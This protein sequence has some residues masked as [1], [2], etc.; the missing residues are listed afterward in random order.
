MK[1]TDKSIKITDLLFYYT[2]NNIDKENV[3]IGQG[4][5]LSQIRSAVGTGNGWFYPGNITNDGYICHMETYSTTQSELMYLSK[6]R[7]PDKLFVLAVKND[8]DNYIMGTIQKT[9]EIIYSYIN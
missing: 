1:I 5:K 3:S 2:T 4:V 6:V 7:M 8:T 9:Q